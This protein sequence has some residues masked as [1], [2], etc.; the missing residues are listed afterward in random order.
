MTSYPT[1]PGYFYWDDHS[2]V[3]EWTPQSQY[4]CN[5]EYSLKLVLN[6]D[7]KETLGH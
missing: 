5:F 1:R 3:S 2:G 6:L 4:G 7:W